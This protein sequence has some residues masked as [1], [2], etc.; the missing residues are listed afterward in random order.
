MPKESKVQRGIGMCVNQEFEE[1]LQ[2]I[3]AQKEAEEAIT[4]SF[5]AMEAL[6]SIIEM[7]NTLKEHEGTPFT[8][9]TFIEYL[10]ANYIEGLKQ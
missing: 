10:I 8:S 3:E 1:A 4:L 6:H 5:T 2:E 9:A 7:E